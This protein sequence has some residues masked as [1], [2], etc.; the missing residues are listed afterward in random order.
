MTNNFFIS[1]PKTIILVALLDR[2]DTF[3]ESLSTLMA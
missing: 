1:R 2:S 3:G